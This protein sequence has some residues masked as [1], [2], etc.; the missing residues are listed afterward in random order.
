M[1]DIDVK[2]QSVQNSGELESKGEAPSSQEVS[3][4][5]EQAL[6]PLKIHFQMQE[7]AL[8]AKKARQ[9]MIQKKRLA[10]LLLKQKKCFPNGDQQALGQY[11][12][13]GQ[14]SIPD[15]LNLQAQEHTACFT[16]FQREHH[17]HQHHIISSCET[18]KSSLSSED[19]ENKPKNFHG[20]CLQLSTRPQ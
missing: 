16:E 18:Y 20:D 8:K 13:K 14:M 19:K 11:P 3:R 15:G 5:K 2:V 4:P 6:D 10:K 17:A 7:D 12:H 9:Q 1:E